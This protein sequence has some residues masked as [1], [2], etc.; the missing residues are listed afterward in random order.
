MLWTY[1]LNYF[2]ETFNELKVD[3]YRI[4]PMERFSVTTID[5]PLKNN[6][7]W[8]SHIFVLDAILQGKISGLP[9]WEPCSFAGIY[10]GH[11][12]FIAG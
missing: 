6:H 12:Q 1:A 2:S 7:V 11:S 10:L 5:I 4:T 9:K 8:V 3:Y